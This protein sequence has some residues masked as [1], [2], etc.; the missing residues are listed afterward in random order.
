M[1][2]RYQ[3]GRS[4]EYYIKYNLERAGFYVIRSAGSHGP[5]DLIALDKN[6]NVYGIQV[7]KNKYINRQLRSEMCNVAKTYNIVPI[8]AYR[9][10]SGWK[11][12]LVEVN[13]NGIDDKTT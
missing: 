7:K 5:F 8:I 12:E 10:K 13:S 9:D 6:G 2:T 1:T 11:Y 4:Y 3:K